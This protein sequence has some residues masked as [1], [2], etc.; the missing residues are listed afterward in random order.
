MRHGF[1]AAI[2]VAMLMG[3]PAA[4]TAGPQIIA[5]NVAAKCAILPDG[6]AAT[7]IVTLN[8][9]TYNFYGQSLV[10]KFTPN[11]TGTPQNI[12]MPAGSSKTVNLAVSPGVYALEITNQ[13]ASGG[14]TSASYNVTV[15]SGM[16]SSLGGRKMCLNREVKER[17]RVN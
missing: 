3:L 4:A 16:V 5:T 8:N 10:F 15:P 7:V 17:V 9:A 11:P 6:T 14:N 1:S 12:P 13:M 2:A